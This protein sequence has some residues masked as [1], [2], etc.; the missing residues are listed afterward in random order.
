MR[1]VAIIQAR[2]GSTRL[3]GKVL[4]TLCGKSVLAHVVDRVKAARRLDAVWIATTDNPA[5]DPLVEECRHLGVPS[6]RGSE[7]D[8]LARYHGAARAS[9]AEAVV[10]ITSDCPLFD[11]ALL[12]EMLMV[13]RQANRRDIT[14]DYVSNVQQRRYPRGLDAEIFTRAALDRAHREARLPHEREHVTPYFYQH[15]DLFRLGSYAGEADLSHLRWTLDTPEDWQFIEAVYRLLYR[16]DRLFTTAE[17]LE[18]LQ[19]QPELAQINCG[20]RQK[21]L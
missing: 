1:I 16:M 6:F 12:D 3:P 20:V 9:E 8:V 10:R 2:V 13:F 4:R 19:R 15:P 11:A 5:D 18:L 17:V 7:S 21:P 14:L